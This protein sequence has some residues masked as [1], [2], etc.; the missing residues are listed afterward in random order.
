MPSGFIWIP[1]ADIQAFGVAHL[2]V[3]A[4]NCLN[5]SA[6]PRTASTIDY[7]LTV[8]VVPDSSPVGAEI[9]LDYRDVGGST[10]RPWFYNVKAGLKE[11][12]LFPW[13]P[14][15][16]L[17]LYDAGGRPDVSAANIVYCLA[18]KTHRRL[19]RL[20]VGYFSGGNRV[21]VDANGKKESHGLLAS[22]DRPIGAK[23][24]AALEYMGSRSSY[25]AFH[26]GAS[27]SL[28]A[29]AGFTV[30]YS[31]YNSSR[32]HAPTMTFQLDIDL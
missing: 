7:G 4:Y 26:L 12:R 16:A 29:S 8:G 13:Q 23:F 10:D 1:S 15:L 11:A 21:L 20:S 22:W 32:L 27:Y 14:A 31:V 30:G 19:G 9:G 25:G 24:K 5:R 17:G 2:G 6:S 18:A 3:D 28:T